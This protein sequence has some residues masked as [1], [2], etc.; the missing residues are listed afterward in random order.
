MTT[1][2]Q[3]ALSAAICVAVIVLILRIR[4][5]LLRPERDENVFTLAVVLCRGDASGIERAVK[6]AP[7]AC[8]MVDVGMDA[9]AQKHAQKI[10]ETQGFDLVSADELREAI[11]EWAKTD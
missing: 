2:A 4:A 11:Y 10:A 1:V 7:C 6:S 8:V 3:A 9:E 5:L